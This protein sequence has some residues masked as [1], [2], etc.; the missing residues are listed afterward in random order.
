MEA[1]RKFIYHTTAGLFCA[2]LMLIGYAVVSRYILNDSSTWVEEMIRFGFIWMFFLGMGEVT[3]TG[4]HLALDM[5]PG[6]LTGK[7]RK[8]LDILIEVA[9]IAFF[10]IMVWYSWRVALINMKQKTPALLIPY[11]WIYMAIPVGGAIMILFAA[12][13]IVGLV[14][15]PIETA[16]EEV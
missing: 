8:A 1:L 9:N 6:F 3:R 10:S 11:G 2:I 12:Q 16:R 4:S 13:R 5:L 7:T 14:R 15:K